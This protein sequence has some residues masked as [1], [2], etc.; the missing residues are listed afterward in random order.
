MEQSM[1]ELMV[2]FG[3]FISILTPIVTSV[4]EVIKRSLP[5]MSK[6]YIPL[7]TIAVAIGL[8][9]LAWVFTDLNSTWRLWGG[10]ISGLASSGLYDVTKLTSRT[11]KKPNL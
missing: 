5:T 4:T 8:G 7:L 11:F 10:L 3:L 1:P 6:N 9:S 2:A